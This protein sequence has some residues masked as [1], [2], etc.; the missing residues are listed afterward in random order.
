M[1][2]SAVSRSV[3]SVVLLSAT[4][5]AL[6]NVYADNAELVKTA[7]ALAC[8]KDPCVRLLRAERTP[9]RQSFTFQTSLSPPAT[10]EVSCERAFLL[11]GSFACNTP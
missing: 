7:E 10:R 11:V 6:Y 3:L 8:G 9:V 1:S 5:A 2:V 4:V